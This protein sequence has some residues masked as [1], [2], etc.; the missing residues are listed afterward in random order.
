M[1][2]P[3]LPNGS[4][5]GHHP[6]TPSPPS[7]AP[8]TASTSPEKPPASSLSISTSHSPALAAS[9]RFQNIFSTLQST[10]LPPQP[11]DPSADAPPRISVADY[12]RSKGGKHSI[13]RILIANNGIAAVKAIRSIRK[14]SHSTPPPPTPTDPPPPPL[15]ALSTDRLSCPPLFCLCRAY[16]TFGNDHAIEFVAMATP[17]DMKVNAAYIHLADEFVSVPGGSN[18]NNYANVQLITDIAERTG[19]HAVWAGW[20]HASENPKLPESLALTKNGVVWMGPPPSAMR[21]LGDKIGSTLIAQTAH[22]PCMPWS[23]TGLTVDYAKTGIPHDLYLE[24][25]VTTAQEAK[26]AA[27]R[28]GY[29]VM[30]KASE[31]GGGK[32]IRRV[33]DPEQV[34]LAFA[35]VQGEV[36]GSPIFLMKLAPTCRHLEVQLLAD[37]HGEAIA[38][39]GRD[40]SIQ[41]RHQKIIEEGPVVAAPPTVWRQMEQSA[42]RLAKEVG[43]IGAG[44][45]EYLYLENGEYYFLELNPR[46]Q[47]E[48]PVTELI[49]GVNLPAAQLQVAMGIPLHNIRGIRRMYGEDPDTETPI[50]FTHREAHTLPGHVIACRVTAENPD[51]EFQPTSGVIQELNFRSTPDVWGYFSVAAKGGVHEYSDSQFGHMFA[52]GETREIARR[53]MVLALK[54]LSIRGDI[55]TTV[56]YLRKILETNDFRRNDISTTWLEQV[57]AKREVI[58]EKPETHLAV[59]LGALYR[60]YR[61]QNLREKEFNEALNRG[62]LPSPQLHQDLV[63]MTQDLIYEKVRTPYPLPSQPSPPSRLSSFSPFFSLCCVRTDEVLNRP[64]PRRVQ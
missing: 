46:L 10:A 39:F 44:T 19:A 27:D 8:P 28:I 58:T 53:N 7:S 50:D 38:I 4:L 43:Y 29:P 17:E 55:R 11:R 33:I 51:M 14:W 60:A 49:S 61:F 47:V 52:L 26:A 48:H 9:P 1:A 31:G 34:D 40:C 41:R 20:G 54:E 25:C 36:P 2:T 23:G 21:A 62:Q 59:L 5:N 15:P 45:V 37:S 35:Q 42:V 16:E 24:A 56:E 32:G 63:E 64:S 6:S 13:T 18:N 22:V 57:M 3:A 30:I 12:V